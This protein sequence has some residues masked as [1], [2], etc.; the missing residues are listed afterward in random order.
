MKWTPKNYQREALDAVLTQPRLQLW[1]DKGLGKTSVALTG[2][3]QMMDEVRIVRTLVISTTRICTSVWPQEIA[4]WDHLNWIP[5]RHLAGSPTQR[6]AM[7]NTPWHGIETI[8][9]ENMRWLFRDYLRAGVPMPWDLVVIDESSKMKAPGTRRFKALRRWQPALPRVLEL[10]GSPAPQG[11]L[12]VWGPA[13]FLDGGLSLAP[14]PTGPRTYANFKERWFS[15]DYMGWK[16]TPRDGAEDMIKDKLGHLTL[17]LKASD[18]LDMPELQVRDLEV[19]LPP[20]CRAQ[21]AELRARMYL[22]LE[23][24]SVEAA[25]GGVL[26]MKC[27]QMANGAM[28]TNVEGTAWE[29]MHDAKLDALDEIVEEAMGRPLIVAYQFKSDL[30]RLRERHPHAAVLGLTADKDRDTIDRWNNEEYA[31]LLMHPQSGGHGLNLQGG[32][33]DMVF[34]GAPWSFDQYDQCMDRIA[35]GLRRTRPTFI[36]R[37]AT[38]DTVDMD[39]LESLELN[40][41]VQEVLKSRMRRTQP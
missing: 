40:C 5:I 3:E 30:A 4:K 33:C 7:L 23:S 8:T 18:Y 36:T 12:G 1:M 13:F 35:G 29:V 6:A 28:Y 16:Y 25:N 38:A 31:M 14:S 39:V 9:F 27:R 17:S 21:Y 41:T 10:T 15:K 20:R 22:A 34:F 19:D 37:I 26:T 24:G 2:I 32:G 11:L